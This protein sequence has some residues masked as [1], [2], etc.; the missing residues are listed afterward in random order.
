MSKPSPS[1]TIFCHNTCWEGKK[2]KSQKIKQNLATQHSTGDL[3]ESCN[4]GETSLEGAHSFP[5]QATSAARF[6]LLHAALLNGFTRLNF[7]FAGV[8]RF[9][10]LLNICCEMLLQVLFWIF[11]SFLHQLL[12]PFWRNFAASQSDP[13]MAP[14]NAKHR[15][16]TSLSVR[17]ALR[18][19]KS[20]TG[21][22]CPNPFP[23]QTLAPK[24]IN[25][26]KE[27]TFLPSLTP[28]R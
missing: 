2:S 6:L 27:G 22:L 5:A 19:T 9:R 7:L 3:P 13:M 12:L 18:F 8:L 28:N 26:P 15:K 11:D 20:A 14:C 17:G 24:L 1:Q 16:S 10:S 4:L 21:G 25:I 23:P